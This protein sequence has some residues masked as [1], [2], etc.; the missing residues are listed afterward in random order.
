MIGLEDQLLGLVVE[1]ER[2]DLEEEKNALVISNAEMKRE[3]K[4]IEDK[5]L[6][7]LATH[8]GK[9]LDDEV[10]ID[11]LGESKKTSQAIKLKVAES[12]E[13]E[14]KIDE[15]RALYKP[16]AVR[17]SGNSFLFVFFLICI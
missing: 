7:L 17:A 13:N 6:V 12:E 10:L 1:K 11:L 5:I 9:P 15:I 3:V 14:K 16:V 4:E 8:K 2:P